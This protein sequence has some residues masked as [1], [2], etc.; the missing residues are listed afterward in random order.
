VRP[1]FESFI[2]GFP[3]FPEFLAFKTLLFGAVCGPDWV[4]R[5]FRGSWLRPILESRVRY[6]PNVGAFFSPKGRRRVAASASRLFRRACPK[7]A[8]RSAFGAG[9]TAWG[10]FAAITGLRAQSFYAVHSMFSG[11]R[12]SVDESDGSYFLASGACHA[13]LPGAMSRAAGFLLRLW[14]RQE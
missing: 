4:L 2:G 8:R 11:E 5:V 9:V 13:S 6:G 1:V 14:T 3:P 7:P 10:G 12:F